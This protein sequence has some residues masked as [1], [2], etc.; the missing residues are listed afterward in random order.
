MS[1]LEKHVMLNALVAAGVPA[2]RIEFISIPG[3]D[4]FP[5]TTPSALDVPPVKQVDLILKGRSIAVIRDSNNESSSIVIFRPSAATR[6]QVKDY[7]GW[8]V[9]IVLDDTNGLFTPR[10]PQRITGSLYEAGND[11]MIVYTENQSC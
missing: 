10:T 4:N 11:T 1:G 3:P 7:E 2:E 6:R 5:D 9:A 8:D